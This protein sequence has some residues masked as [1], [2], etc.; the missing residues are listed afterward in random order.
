MLCTDSNLPTTAASHTRLTSCFSARFFA[1]VKHCT[2]LDCSSVPSEGNKSAASAGKLE[3]I[4][5]HLGSDFTKSIFVMDWMIK[6][7]KKCLSVALRI[8]KE[9]ETVLVF[10]A[11]F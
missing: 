10:R 6:V 7:L 5:L 2:H 1:S 4:I 8:G 9:R 3:T 11:F